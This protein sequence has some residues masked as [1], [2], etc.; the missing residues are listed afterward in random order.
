MVVVSD[1]SPLIILSKLGQLEVLRTLFNTVLIPPEVYD[2]LTQQTTKFGVSEIVNA[3]SDW[4]QVQTP[5]STIQYKGLHPGETAA[6]A[7]AKEV[8][9]DF[10]IMDEKAGRQVAKRELLKTIG[11]IGILEKAA[12]L[13]HLDLAPTF[14][15]LKLLHFHI[16][17]EFLDVRLKAFEARQAKKG[18]P[19]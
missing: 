13:E 8:S 16:R 15:Q 11:T 17:P 2:E 18:P 5:T 9:A 10:L 1:S 14:E 19:S 12:E 4:L 6:I 7:L 3:A